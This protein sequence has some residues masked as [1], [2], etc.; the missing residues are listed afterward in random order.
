MKI[1][2]TSSMR[3]FIPSAVLGLGL[4][5]VSSAYA[6]PYASYLIDINS[7]EV[8]R[9]ESLVSGGWTIATAIND[10]GMVVGY[11]G[12]A[13]RE[14]AFI[15][16]PKGIGI[17]DLGTLGGGWSSPSDINNAGQVVGSSSTAEGSQRA[18]ITGPDGYGMTELQTRNDSQPGSSASGINDAG[19]VVGY[20]FNESLNDASGFITG[21]NGTGV[22]Y[23]SPPNSGTLFIKINNAGQIIGQDGHG[24]A[25]ITGPDGAGT[26]SLG[27][28]G[29]VT[30]AADI[31]NSGQV[32]G[33][34]S[35][36]GNFITG[37]DGAGLWNLG[38][39]A[40]PAFGLNDAGQV[41]GSGP[42]FITGPNGE[43]IVNLN[44]LVNLPEGVQLQ[45]AAGINNHGQVIAI[46]FGSFSTIPTIPEPEIFGM[47]LAG[48]GLV[49]S[50]AR[51][52]IR[53]GKC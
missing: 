8:T 45:Y 13:D 28:P 36:G 16:G 17:R 14:H 40:G 22:T 35:V 31:N 51:R 9:L 24:I 34:S 12:T 18:F 49:G 48:L 23:L 30:W 38:S 53:T 1:I 33:Y 44:S 39:S 2:R 42:S 46:T 19:Q 6:D 32:A 26:T 10:A 43:G 4:G 37:P 52:K 5:F 41:V 7:R 27:S 25:F 47:L 50:M 15:T 11:S 20:S 21:P 3:S 29:G